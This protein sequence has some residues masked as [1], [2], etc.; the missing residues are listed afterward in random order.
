MGNLLNVC[1][2]GKFG[3]K[4]RNASSEIDSNTMGVLFNIHMRGTKT[5]PRDTGISSQLLKELNTMSVSENNEV[6]ARD[7][8]I[9][10]MSTNK[11]HARKDYED[12]KSV[13][14]QRHQDISYDNKS[15]LDSVNSEVTNPSLFICQTSDKMFK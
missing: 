9:Q 10:R 12:A 4:K 15:T 14:V 8:W 11:D 3:K 7:R 6:T 5:R 13:R 2:G 1:C